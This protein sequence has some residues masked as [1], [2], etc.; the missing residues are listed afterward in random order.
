MHVLYVVTHFPAAPAKAAVFTTLKTAASKPIITVPAST[1]AAP[2]VVAPAVKI[3]PVLAAA[4]PKAAQAPTDH[5]SD[6][7]CYHDEGDSALIDHCQASSMPSWKRELLSR[8]K[9][10]AK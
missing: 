10:G 6:E 5:A 7:V 4:A 3:D 9:S 8:Q 1:T 2:V